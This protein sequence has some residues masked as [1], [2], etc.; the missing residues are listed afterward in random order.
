[1]LFTNDTANNFNNSDNTLGTAESTND[2]MHHTYTDTHSFV[3]K[4][5]RATTASKL[6]KT[7]LMRQKVERKF[8]LRE[9]NEF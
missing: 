8:A 3:D 4:F 1:M 7:N 5:L 2:S 6:V 9:Y